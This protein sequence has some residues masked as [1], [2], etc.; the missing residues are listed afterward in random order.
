MAT[1]SLS[2]ARRLSPSSTPTSTAM[3][4]VTLKVLGRVKSRISITFEKVELLRTTI[5]RMWGRSRMKR[6]KV[7]SAHPMSVWERISPRM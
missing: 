2:E 4:M 7:K 1:I 5:S 6:M 3:G